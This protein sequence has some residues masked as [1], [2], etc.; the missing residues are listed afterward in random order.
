MTPNIR[1]F[2]ASLVGAVALVVSAV[3]GGVVVMGVVTTVG[4]GS[5]SAGA[6]GGA[7]AVCGVCAAAV[8]MA[9]T[10]ANSPTP[11]ETT[12]LFNL[13]TEFTLPLNWK[14]TWEWTD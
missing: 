5:P 1:R 3:A 11:D 13:E 8:E 4:V 10:K 9:A 7:L 14:L 12:T 6:G 2:F